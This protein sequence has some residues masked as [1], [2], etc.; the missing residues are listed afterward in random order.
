MSV[1]DQSPMCLQLVEH[2]DNGAEVYRWQLLYVSQD[3]TLVSNVPDHMCQLQQRGLH[4]YIT[5][6]CPGQDRHS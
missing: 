2:T 6:C 3:C 4:D 1:L 5:T